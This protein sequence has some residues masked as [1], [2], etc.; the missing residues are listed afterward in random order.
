MRRPITPV[1]LADRLI[2]DLGEEMRCLSGAVLGGGLVT[3][4]TWANLQVPGDY[5]RT[6]PLAHLAEATASLDPPVLGMLTAAEVSSFRDIV[7]GSARAIA[8]VGLGSPLAAAGAV[9]FSAVGE[10]E[11]AA[12]QGR[13]A[14]RPGTINILVVV[15]APLTDAG[16]VGAF[17]TA[18]EAKVQALSEARVQAH[19]GAGWATG[20]ATDVLAMVCP[21]GSTV[22]FAGPATTV[23]ADLARAVYH[24][25][26]LGCPAGSGARLR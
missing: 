16:L 18:V 5:A 11:V 20:T 17:Q 10:G 24:A 13:A 19:N 8:T 25:V 4:R 6:D 14:N 3:V 7:V 22:G 15:D 21:P 2:V 1:L 9:G 23:G 26:R 12:G